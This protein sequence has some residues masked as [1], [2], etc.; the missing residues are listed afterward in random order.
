MNTRLA[1]ANAA[2]VAATAPGARLGRQTGAQ[3]AAMTLAALMTF[4]T[5]GSVHSLAAA[6]AA[7]G[8]LARAAMVSPQA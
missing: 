1:T 4:G 2:T 6:D 5:L 8:Q 3:L 7:Q